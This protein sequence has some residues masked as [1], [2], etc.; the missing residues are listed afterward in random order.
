M[1]LFLKTQNEQLRE[2][3]SSRAIS[4]HN[5]D[6]GFDL[7]STNTEPI[8]INPGETYKINFEI[9]CELRH[10]DTK[11]SYLLMPRSSI[12]KTPLRMANSIG[13]IDAEY[14]G[15]IMAVVDNIKDRQYVIEPGTRLFQLVAPSLLPFTNLTLIDDF[16]SIS[17]R[18]ERGFGEGTSSQ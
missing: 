17:S 15:N 11:V 8:T 4:F 12:I 3:Y 18:G 2:Y 7:I 13:L 9:Q 14:Q 16:S 5:G 6:S 10:N 1:H